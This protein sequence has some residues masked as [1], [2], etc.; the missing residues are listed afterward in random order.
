MNSEHI[1]PVY[2]REKCGMMANV[3]CQSIPGTQRRE[4]YNL[5]S[6]YY[7]II[8]RSVNHCIYYA[9][10]TSMESTFPTAAPKSEGRYQTSSLAPQFSITPLLRK[11]SL[12]GK[13][14]ITKYNQQRTVHKDTNNYSCNAFTQQHNWSGHTSVCHGVRSISITSSLIHHIP[15]KK[16]HCRN[17][18][19]YLTLTAWIALNWRIEQK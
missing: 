18:I 11:I 10:R 9:S 6:V 1:V 8:E 19:W 13:Q 15:E 7:N 5:Y 3:V 17:V 14:C 12:H 4:V 16:T 2:R